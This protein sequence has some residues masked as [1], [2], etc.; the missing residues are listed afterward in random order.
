M[1]MVIFTDRIRYEAWMKAV[2]VLSILLLAG[3]GILFE[4]DA[5]GRDIFSSEPP[6]ESHLAAVV[7]WLS[8][9]FVA[10]VFALVLPRRISVLTEGIRVE[11]AAFGWDISFESVESVRRTRRVVVFRG[12][13]AITSY[14][15][16][17]EI[18]RTSGWNVLISPD[19]PEPFVA[20]A[21]RALDA[22]RRNH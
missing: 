7:L 8:A 9:V 22:F 13:S 10:I 4:A 16:R 6:R 2:L 3:L 14:R 1:D 17:V 12:F 5:S 19:R 21:N 20:E 18:A 11:F 15:N